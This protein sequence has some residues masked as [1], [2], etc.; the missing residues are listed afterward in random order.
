MPKYQCRLLQFLYRKINFSHLLTKCSLRNVNLQQSRVTSLGSHFS[1][2]FGFRC[3]ANLGLSWVLEGLMP[4][5][6][7]G[8]AYAIMIIEI[9]SLVQ[10]GGDLA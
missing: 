10:T 6:Y 2:Q 5:G 4:P 3:S 7:A 1:I 8:Y 9:F